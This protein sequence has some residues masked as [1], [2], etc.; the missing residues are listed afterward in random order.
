MMSEAL[1]M[2]V[3][4]REVLGRE[5][6]DEDSFGMMFAKPDE[7]QEGTRFEGEDAFALECFGCEGAGRIRGAP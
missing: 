5:V 2:E 3:L 6:L 4:G 7:W 1:G